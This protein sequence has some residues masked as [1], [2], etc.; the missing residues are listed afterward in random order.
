MY[1]RS[2]GLGKT[3]L[4]G[5]IVKAEYTNIVPETLKDPPAGQNE[6]HRLLCTIQTIAPVT[7]QVRVFVEPVD[8]RF[9]IGYLFKNPKVLFSALSMLIFGG[10]STSMTVKKD[11]KAAPVN[12]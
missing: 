12:S 6:P 11:G 2:T 5:K 1:M 9:F 7:W 8:V 3:L 10:K 4:Q